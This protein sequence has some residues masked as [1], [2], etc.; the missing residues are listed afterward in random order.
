MKPVNLNGLNHPQLQIQRTEPVRP[1]DADKPVGNS[2]SASDQISVSNRAGEVGHLIARA[3][4]LDDVRQDRV[5]P[6]R[7]LIHSGQ[8][9]VS[10]VRI[11]DAIIRDENSR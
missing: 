10:S 5:G 1:T 4:Q 6:L 8:Y 11:A 2:G 3:G 9:E 7:Q